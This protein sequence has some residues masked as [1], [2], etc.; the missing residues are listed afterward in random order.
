M[1]FLICIVFMIAIKSIVIF[2]VIIPQPFNYVGIV[3]V[4]AG[5]LMMMVVS[6]VFNQLNTEIHTFRQPKKLVT[7][8]LFKISRNPIYLGFTIMLVGVWVLLGTLLPIIGCLVF[9]VIADL[10]YIPYEER[11]MEQIFGNEYL[12]YKTKVRRWL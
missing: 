11:T 1:L 2:K 8:G 12:A 3:P 5:A 10:W 7:T 9:I 4:V 6:K